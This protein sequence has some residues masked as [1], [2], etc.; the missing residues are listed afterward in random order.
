[1]SV[2]AI[3]KLLS[4]F[5]DSNL[6]LD[7][8]SQVL[9]HANVRSGSR[10][11]VVESCHGVLLGAILERLG[12]FSLFITLKCSTECRIYMYGSD[13]SGFINRTAGLVLFFGRYSVHRRKCWC[14]SSS[15]V[16][17]GYPL[18]LIPPNCLWV[19]CP[20]TPNT[21]LH[22]LF[23]NTQLMSETV[24]FLTKAW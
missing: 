14:N 12:G 19:W 4:C 1:M 21:F 17:S 7:S 3:G 10:L 11:M 2:S 13:D 18:T 8:L 5:V 16:I 24:A 23:S 20:Q 9:N 22:I 6:R 15:W